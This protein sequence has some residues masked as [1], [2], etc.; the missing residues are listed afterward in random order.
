MLFL[1]R[2]LSEAYLEL[3]W[4]SVMGFVVQGLGL[5]AFGLGA[6]VGSGA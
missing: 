6:L 2:A 5:R 4:V 3:K 1:L